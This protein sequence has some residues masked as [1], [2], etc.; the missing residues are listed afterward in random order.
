MGSEW[1]ANVSR[2]SKAPQ[3]FDSRGSSY[4][5]QSSRLGS[6]HRSHSKGWRQAEPIRNLPYPLAYE[7]PSPSDTCS[8]TDTMRAGSFLDDGRISLKIRMAC[9]VAREHGYRYIWIDSC[10]ID[11]SSSTELSEAINSMYLWYSRA[12]ICYAFLADVPDDDEPDSED[13]AFRHSRWFT[14]GWTLQE[15][16]APRLVVFLSDHWSALGTKATLATVVEEVTRIDQAVLLH[17]KSL[18]EV[19]VAERMAWASE[20][21]T[22]R[23]EDQAYALLGIFDINMPTLYGEGTRAFRRLQEE[24][25]KRIPD[26]SLFAW[27]DAYL[28]P[29]PEAED[30]L[31]DLR[32]FVCLTK[33]SAR[34]LFAAS[35]AEFLRSGS[36]RRVPHNAYLRRLGLFN[37]PLPEYASSPYGTRLQ[38][39]ILP[40]SLCLPPWSVNYQERSGASEW[41][42][43]LLAC[44]P[45]Q[46][47]GHLLARVCRMVPSLHCQVEELQ[48]GFVAITQARH[49]SGYPKSF[50]LSPSQITQFRSDITNKTVYLPHQERVLSPSPNPTIVSRIFRMTLSPWASAVLQKQGYDIAFRNPTQASPSTYYLFLS[51][52]DHTL[53]MEFEYSQDSFVSEEGL[54]VA[55][56]DFHLDAT[57]STAQNDSQAPCP[58]HQVWWESES[59]FPDFE[60]V[61]PLGNEV[62]LQLGLDAASGSSDNSFNL[63]VEV[64]RRRTQ[65]EPI[66]LAAA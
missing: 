57:L 8:S 58:V 20:R 66:S 27:G 37:V 4:I 19:S 64:I 38:L 32:R 52:D 40:I 21:A 43:A 54:R 7:P 23:V 18:D 62:T 45:S 41:C 16:I 30:A 63:R 6:W 17:Q 39:P 10:C 34:S 56:W 59:G 28:Q 51:R 12:T 24:I 65:R 49:Y 13:S 50:T 5:G 35:P 44:E 42:F 2:A 55:I 36:I 11:K 22:T 29:L 26:Q 48:S 14:R 53:K 15:L 31:L 9:A 60:L 46:R 25:L 47:P 61:D 3:G 1:R 33:Y